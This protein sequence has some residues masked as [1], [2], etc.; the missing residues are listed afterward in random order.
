MGGCSG[1][2]SSATQSHQKFAA[3]GRGRA[4]RKI[5]Q[6]AARVLLHIA[7]DWRLWLRQRRQ[8][9]D[10]WNRFERPA[11]NNDV[12]MSEHQHKIA[13]CTAPD[14]WPDANCAKHLSIILARRLKSIASLLR[15]NRS[16]EEREE[17]REDISQFKFLS[18]SITKTYR[19]VGTSCDRSAP[20]LCGSCVGHSDP[21]AFPAPSSNSLPLE[22]GEP[23]YAEFAHIC[24]CLLFWNGKAP[25]SPRRYSAEDGAGKIATPKMYGMASSRTSVTESLTMLR[26]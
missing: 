9:A 13:N 3:A 22:G 5:W 14:A 15:T 12:G 2:V 11:Q 16:G 19:T 23:C 6:Q 1:S 18:N 21:A 26:L 20:P 8:E 25:H 10:G 24:S 7:G 17:E 4:P